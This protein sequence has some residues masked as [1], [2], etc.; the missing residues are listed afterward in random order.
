MPILDQDINLLRFAF[1]FVLVY[2]IWPNL[3]FRRTGEDWVERFFAGLI[4]MLALTIVL[5]YLLVIIKLYE[6]L[7]LFWILMAINVFLRLPSGKRAG[8]IRAGVSS[9]S[10]WIF[11]FL[12]GR[13]HPFRLLQARIY[14]ESAKITS[15]ARNLA[16][17]EQLI[18]KIM[19]AAVLLAAAV[20]RFIEPL[21]HAAPLMSDASITLAEV[22]FLEHR[23]LFPYGIYPMGYHIY[24]SVLRKFSGSDAIYILKYAG[25][26]SGVLTT[27]GVYL[28]V[29]KLS[30]RAVPAIAAA[31]VYGVMGQFLPIEWGRQAASNNQEFALAFLL[32]AWHYVLQFLETGRRDYL[33]TAMTAFAVIGFVHSLI[34]AFVWAGLGCLLFAYLL[35]RTRE[36]ILKIRKV[37]LAVGLAGIVAALPLPLGLLYGMSFNSSTTDFL[38]EQ[39][40][41]VTVPAVTS[42]DKLALA[43]LVL[44]MLYTVWRQRTKPALVQATFIMLT[45]TASFLMYRYLGVLTHNAVLIFRMGILWAMLATVGCGLGLGVILKLLPG[46]IFRMESVICFGLLAGVVVYVRPDYPQTY[47]MQYDSNVNQYL[48]ISAEYTATEWMMVSEPEGYDLVLFRS[49]HMQLR[50]FLQKYMNGNLE[51]LKMKDIF[52]VSEK[53]VY[54][55]DFD[56]LK[57]EMV[58]REKD[59]AELAQW[60]DIYKKNH[61]DLSVYYDDS[62]ITVYHIHRP[63]TNQER[64]D[65]I[66]GN[67]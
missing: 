61:Q 19:F 31:F 35:F 49:W 51:E 65:R 1:S 11:D 28:F 56:S 25:P 29:R 5:V 48:R 40:Q 59:Y 17:N 45:G 16:V 63:V 2:V 46:R 27:L 22:K 57:E 32:P 36:G 53:K 20:M 4:R 23:I 10:L 54:P 26:L 14:T 18:E 55:V 6:L 15:S 37:L 33:W 39:I 64:N 8:T 43:G 67:S 52:I 30:G 13:V 21:Q 50:E 41:T 44:F 34:L 38:T 9:I 47:R 12:D 3:M 60:V 62:D 66:W 7:S 58:Q 42:M 24:L